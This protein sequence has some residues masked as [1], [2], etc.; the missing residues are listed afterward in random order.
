MN[1]GKNLVSP[2]SVFAKLS[3]TA[4]AQREG[5][6]PGVYP[7]SFPVRGSKLAL[8][9]HMGME[10]LGFDAICPTVQAPE[11]TV[12]GILLETHDIVF[13]GHSDEFRGDS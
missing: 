5:E 11:K 8:L 9:K 1:S 13:L 6:M 3:T 10:Y 12:C 4:R 7:S 2:A